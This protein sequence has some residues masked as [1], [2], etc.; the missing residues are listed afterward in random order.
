MV[1]P[2]NTQNTQSTQVLHGNPKRENH[3]N[4]YSAILEK[5]QNRAG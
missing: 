2:I 4:K 3:R 1:K 5:I